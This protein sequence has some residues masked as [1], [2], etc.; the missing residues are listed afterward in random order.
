MRRGAPDWRPIFD[1]FE[2]R[3]DERIAAVCDRRI[4]WHTL[5]PGMDPVF[6]GR[7]GVKRWRQTIDEALTELT[8]EVDEA[9][10]LD[11]NRV[12]LAYW[13]RAHGRESGVAAHMRIYDVWTLRRGRLLHRTTHHT[14]EDALAA[15]GISAENVVM[16][17]PAVTP[18]VPRAAA[19]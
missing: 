2:S 12:L 10:E 3:D 19:A 5:W 4:R 15:A 13:V 9:I 8:L 17:A 11:R 7:A 14:R 6:H 16:P 18:R 1:A